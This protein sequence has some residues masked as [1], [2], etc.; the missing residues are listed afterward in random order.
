MGGSSIA[1]DL[2]DSLSVINELNG[3]QISLGNKIT[4]KKSD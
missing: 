3:K 1:T 4:N 2:E